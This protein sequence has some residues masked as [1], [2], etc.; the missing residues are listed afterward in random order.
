MA[1]ETIPRIATLLDVSKGSV[2]LWLRGIALPAPV[3]QIMRERAQQN[4]LLAQE[5]RRT[6]T[7]RKLDAASSEAASLVARHKVNAG[8]ALIMCSLMYWCE[9]A[10]SRNDSEFTFTNAEPLVVAG[11]LSLLRRAVPLDERKFRV[12]MH[13]HEY[14]SE[15]TQKAFWSSVTAIPEQQFSAT[16][17]KPHTG[18]SIKA[19]YP[20]CIHLRYYDVA[21]ARRIYAT[22][23]AFLAGVVK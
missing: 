15:P 19:G 17:W 2:S 7:H 4:R 14:H 23:R 18:K 6:M 16:Y 9:G 8:Q 13:L 10:K 20:G 12:R 1:G 3:Q 22:A 11:F 5:T 21:V